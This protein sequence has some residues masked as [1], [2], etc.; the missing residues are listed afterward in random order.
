MQR[1][2]FL[3]IHEVI[4]CIKVH[5]VGAFMGGILLRE[6]KVRETVVSDWSKGKIIRVLQVA[7][8]RVLG[9]SV[10]NVQVGIEL[11]ET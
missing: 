7:L 8:K 2:W 11:K 10:L 3:Q 5:D 1:R 6:S 9:A 4:F